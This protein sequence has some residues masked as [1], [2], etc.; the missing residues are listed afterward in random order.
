MESPLAIFAVH[1]DCEQNPPPP[2][3]RSHVFGS[4]TRTRTN[5]WF[6]ESHP[7]SPKLNGTVL[8]LQ[9]CPRA[10]DVELS[11]SHEDFFSDLSAG[12]LPI[13]LRAP[14]GRAVGPATD[15]EDC[16]AI[17]EFAVARRGARVQ[18]GA[19]SGQGWSAG[20]WHDQRGSS[21]PSLRRPGKGQTRDAAEGR[22]VREEERRKRCGLGAIRAGP[23]SSHRRWS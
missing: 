20:P 17:D 21:A 2:P 12:R 18:A 5:A 13:F 7:G 4:R 1:W 14:F 19:R 11:T 15:A 8:L 23:A 16:S 22:R 9:P 6:L 10:R 3:P